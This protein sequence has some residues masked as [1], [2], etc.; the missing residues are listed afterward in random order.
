[1]CRKWIPDLLQRK[2]VKL[3]ACF[4]RCLRMDETWNVIWVSFVYRE[5]EVVMRREWWGRQMQFVYQLFSTND[6]QKPDFDPWPAPSCEDESVYFRR[7]IQLHPVNKFES[8]DRGCVNFM[9]ANLYFESEFSKYWT[10][11]MSL[12]R[13]YENGNAYWCNAEW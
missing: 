6:L 3:P 8:N 4:S 13:F 2:M 7:T 12:F 5:S 10:E 1:M 11:N 9:L